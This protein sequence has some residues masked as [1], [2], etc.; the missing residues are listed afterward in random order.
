MEQESIARSIRGGVPPGADDLPEGTNI[1]T[2]F[3]LPQVTHIWLKR[4][5]MINMKV[6][7]KGKRNKIQDKHT[8]ENTFVRKLPKPGK[9]DKR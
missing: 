3:R 6:E 1:T 4:E 2:A 9:E 5:R 8:Q 7:I